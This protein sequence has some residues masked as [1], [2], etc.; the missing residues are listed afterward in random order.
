MRLGIIQILQAMLQ[1]AQERVRR[2]QLAH[3]FRREHV[4]D[5]ERVQYLKRRRRLQLT[6]AS[7]A[8]QLMGL[9]NEL[10]LANSTRAELYMVGQFAAG[11]VLP[12]LGVE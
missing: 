12:N 5:R 2:N 7:A 6:I 9:R 1:P 10:D 3:G 8:D 11:D 4:F